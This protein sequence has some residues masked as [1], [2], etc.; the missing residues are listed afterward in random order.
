[1]RC[2]PRGAGF[3]RQHL[4]SWVAAARVITG[5]LRQKLDRRALVA[6]TG[7]IRRGLAA[8][9]RVQAMWRG[10]GPRREYQRRL[11]AVRRCQARI[12]TTCWSLTQAPQMD[13][14]LVYAKHP[15]VATAAS[16]TLM[17]R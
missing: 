11:H 12:C 3:A 4:Q 8:A 13:E 6:S 5:I 7:A 14:M 17:A 15:M 1:M 16:W 9:V 10:R 2:S